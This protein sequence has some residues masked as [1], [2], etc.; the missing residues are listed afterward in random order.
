MP[1]TQSQCTRRRKKTK[2]K[3]QELS[4]ACKQ[5]NASNYCKPPSKTRITGNS[6]AGM[7]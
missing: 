4:N 1:N 5:G 6:E 7:R 3:I 2:Q